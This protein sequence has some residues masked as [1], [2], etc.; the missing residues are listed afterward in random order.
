M[1]LQD[2]QFL[3]FKRIAQIPCVQHVDFIVEHSL[4]ECRNIWFK[5]ALTFEGL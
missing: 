3:N 5:E 2:F 4:N 1:T